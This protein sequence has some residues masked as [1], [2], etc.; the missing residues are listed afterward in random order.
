MTPLRLSND[1]VERD[2][3]CLLLE[4]EGGGVACMAD[5][6]GKPFL[7]GQYRVIVHITA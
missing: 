2:G 1:D 4:D 7:P 5:A 3:D 6:G